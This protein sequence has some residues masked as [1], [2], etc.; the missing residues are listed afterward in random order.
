MQLL[1]T[2]ATGFVGRH[3]VPRALAAGYDVSLLLRDHLRS[4]AA[5]PEPLRAY[6]ADVQIVYADLRDDQATCAAVHAAAP[7]TVLHLAAAGVTE[8]F[9]PVSQA[10]P[11]NVAGTA[12]LLQA[13]FTGKVPV[14]QVVVARTPGEREALNIYAASKA[15][16]WQFC[17]MYVRTQAWP[18]NGAMIFQ[19]YGPG[20]SEHNLV[21]G[22][23][24]TALAGTDFA[25]TKG[26]QIRDWIW[27][28]DVVDG[29]LAMVHTPQPPGT[30]VELGT[31]CGTSVAGVVSLIYSL[32]GSPGRPLPGTLPDRP[33]ESAVQLAD[34]RLGQRALGWEAT[35]HL[36]DGLRRMIAARR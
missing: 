11:H 1:I 27:I 19:A 32:T 23:L 33:G 20:Q 4:E 13:C 34:T 15:A 2:G 22:A 18:I 28:E 21:P 7:D 16:A 9:L 3:L 6:R 17:R 29:L 8:P 36:E 30:T 12:N 14:R 35:V 25:M 5:L 24:A 31:G 26:H 10:I